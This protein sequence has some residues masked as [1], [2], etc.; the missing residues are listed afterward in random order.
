MGKNVIIF[1][2]DMNLFVHID[3]KTKDILNL[4]EDQHKD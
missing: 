3:N 2:A 1:G 4:C